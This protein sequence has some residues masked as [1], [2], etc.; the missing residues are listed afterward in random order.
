MTMASSPDVSLVMPVYNEEDNIAPLYEEIRTALGDLSLSYDIVYV[1]DGSTDATYARIQD[2]HEK[3]ARVQALRFRRNFGQTAA[4]NAGFAKAQG[5]V[6]VVLDGDLQNDPADIPRLLE[7]LEDDD[8]DVV[9]GW[10]HPRRD[11]LFGKRLP[12]AVSNWLARALT[13]VAIHDS[14]CSLKAYRRE[15][16]EGLELYGEMHRYIP[17]L[18]AIQGY[19]IGEVP[20]NHRRRSHG[21]TKYGVSRFLHGL[22]DLLYVKYWQDYATRPLHFFGLLGVL[23]LFLA[24]IIGMHKIIWQRIV[25]LVPLELGPLLLLFLLFSMNGILFIMLGFLG[26]IMVRSYYAREGRSSY[27]IRE[28]LG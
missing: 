20:V 23:Q 6:V 4:L 3:D 13:G 18:L 11:P 14:G 1:D 15:S 26:E 5:D 22:L 10:R 7:K 24:G 25:L 16:L 21:K 8:L 12:S 2:L 9:S 17:A 19:R 27:T 28:E